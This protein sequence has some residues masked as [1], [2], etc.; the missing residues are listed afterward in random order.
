VHFLSAQPLRRQIVVAISGL[1][2]MLASAIWWSADRT[3]AERQEEVRQEARSVAR[4][5]AAYLNQYFDGLDAM[6]SALIRHPAIPALDST[7]CGRLFADLL[8]EQP[9][10]LNVVLR[11]RNAVLVASATGA[12]ADRTSVPA[13]AYMLEVLKTGRPGVSELIAGPLTGRATV[14]Q[15]YPVHAADGA[16]VG[17]LALSLNLI[18]LQHVFDNLALPN[19]SVVTLLDQRG[20]IL[21][22]SPDG[23]KYIGRT[24]GRGAV[25]M[26][27]LGLRSDIDGIERFVGTESVARGPWSLSV[28]IPQAVVADRLTPFWWR[29]LTITLAAVL[30]VLG[31]ALWVS[32]HTSTGLE[33]IRAAA[34]R[35]AGGDLSPPARARAPNLEIAELQKAFITMAANLRATRDALDRQVEQERR[36]RE[37]VQSLQRQVVRQERLAAVGLLVSGVAHELNNPLQ[38]ILGTAELLERDPTLGVEALGEITLLKTQSE[39][40]REIIRNLSRFG[41]QQSGPPTLVDLRTVIAEVVQ[42]RRHDLEKLSIA[43]DVELSTSSKVYANITEL[44]QV[45]LNFVINAQQAIE[46]AGRGHGRILMRLSEAGRK[47]RLEVQDDGPGVSPENEAKLF[48]PFFTTKPVGKGTGL[49]LSVSYGIID[50]Y[51]G[52]I[53]CHGNEWSGAT[54][55]FELPAADERTGEA[56]PATSSSHA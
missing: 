34:Q 52:A 29:N 3:R 31:L 5:A 36:M 1:L 48:Q 18:Q 7:E 13:P 41:S 11:D 26:P 4:L 15:A 49:G 40:A 2:L 39:R 30:A 25:P 21:S 45:T 19:G 24:I 33:R 37:M 6:A 44:E 10:L 16:M 42:L 54:F 9:L 55:F 43:I 32:H 51:G 50:S 27:D 20:Q 38:A 47:V 53:G 22:R 8:S 56:V 12:P 35:I 14:G 17:V 46:S 28:G 23:E